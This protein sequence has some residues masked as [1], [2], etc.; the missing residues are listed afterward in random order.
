M[1]YFTLKLIHQTAV[2]L[3][4]CGFVARGAGSLAGAAWVRGRAARS[5]PHLVDSVLLLSALTLAFTLRLDPVNAPWL[6]AKLTALMV[7]IGLGIVALR[8]SFPLRTR[9]TAWVAALLTFGYMVSVA[10]TKSPAGVFAS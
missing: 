5:V 7:Y 10:I 1:D 4:F 2:A 8:Q 9:A 6:L 3:S